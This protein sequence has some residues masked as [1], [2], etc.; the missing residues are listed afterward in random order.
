VPYLEPRVVTL[1]DDQDVASFNIVD[2]IERRLQK[3]PTFRR[4][5]IAASELWKK[6]DLYRKSSDKFS[7][8]TDGAVARFHPHLMRPAT[9]EESEDLRIALLFNC[10]DIEV[11]PPSGSRDTLGTRP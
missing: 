4:T 6:G 2:L 3:D 7:D 10:D 5:V 1:G 8:I 9:P 11:P